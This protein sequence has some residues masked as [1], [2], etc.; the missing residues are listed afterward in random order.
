MGYRLDAFRATS[1]SW[2]YDLTG[3]DLGTIVAGARRR[4]S[5]EWQAYAEDN[6]DMFGVRRALTQAYGLTYTPDP[7]WTVSGGLEVG[8]VFDDTID[9]ATGFENPDFD[10]QALSLSAAYRDEDRV[11]AK[12]KGELR[13]DDSEDDSRDVSSYLAALALGLR[14]SED[15]RALAS[16]DAVISEASASTRDGEYI[17]ASLGFAYRPAASDRFNALAKYTFLYDKPGADQVS[18]DGTTSGPLQVSHIAAIDASYD[19]TPKLTIGGKYG[20]RMGDRRERDAGATWDM[21]VVQLGILRADLHVVHNWDALLE[22]RALWNADAGQVDTGVLAAVYRHLGDNMKL[23]VGYNF[24]MFS[25]DLRDLVHDDRGA[26]I[27]L[28]GKW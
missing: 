18:V 17:E 25:D 9:P 28:V 24:G 14:V 13:F 27:N 12:A 4:F 15:W 1:A 6:Y 26:F 10:R 16:L 8:H 2:P 5:E 23:G 3:R 11:D 22:A 21:E 20:V 19:L 7:Y